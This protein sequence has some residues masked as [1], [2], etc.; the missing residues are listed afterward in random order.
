MAIHYNDKYRAAYKHLQKTLDCLSKFD[1]APAKLPRYQRDVLDC[2]ESSSAEIESPS[3]DDTLKRED[4]KSL[5][6]SYANEYADESVTVE[7]Q[8]QGDLSRPTV[9]SFWVSVSEQEQWHVKEFIPPNDSALDISSEHGSHAALD[10]Y[11]D[12]TALLVHGEFGSSRCFYDDSGAGLAWSMVKQGYHVFAIDITGRK[13]SPRL[14]GAASLTARLKS[15]FADASD[16]Q[17]VREALPRVIAA[18]GQRCVNQA[19]ASFM[20][21]YSQC[22]SKIPVESK[23]QSESLE[24]F[25]LA[26]R[27]IR[28]PRVWVAHGFGAALLAAAW[29]RMPDSA[30]L[31]KRMV[32][33]EGHRYWQ[34]G[35]TLATGLA[36]F[37]S[38]GLARVLTRALGRFPARKLM[39]GG[40]DEPAAVF[41]IYSRWI[42]SEEWLDPEDGYDYQQALAEKPLPAILHIMNESENCLMPASAVRRFSNELAPVSADLIGIPSSL[43]ALS[44]ESFSDQRAETGELPD[45]NEIPQFS[46]SGMLLHPEAEAWLFQPMMQWLDSVNNL[47]ESKTALSSAEPSSHDS[48]FSEGQQLDL[49]DFLPAPA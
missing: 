38:S 26:Q 35:S 30:H 9:R 12:K 11:M 40:T 49:S 21:S 27:E 37:L 22:E 24:V 39:L 41:D 33:F 17:L 28:S 31:A 36:K 20:A 3:L 43:E 19:R 25:N 10:A 7:E 16:T 29:T 34:G 42:G 14:A 5:D 48:T 13:R 6:A 2:A 4:V 1:D 47:P 18:C 8:N 23:S 44:D 15:L 32:F 46:Y 45:D